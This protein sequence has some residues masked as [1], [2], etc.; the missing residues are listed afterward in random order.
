MKK[1]PD[2]RLTRRGLLRGALGVPFALPLLP[3][4]S[5]AQEASAP[6]KRFIVFFHPNGTMPDEW[7]PTPGVDEESFVLG[8]ILAPLE[9]H[10][11]D[12]IIT[13]G[14]D[15]S[16][17]QQGP[18]EPHQR[19]MGGLLTGRPLLEGEFV[20][21]DGSLAGWGSG[22]SVDQRIA[23]AIGQSTRLRS[24]LLGVRNDHPTGAGEVRNRLSYLGPAQPLP[25]EGDPVAAFN[26]LFSD[27]GTDPGALLELR[28]RRR[29]VLDA[30]LDQFSLVTPKLSADDRARLDSHAALVRDLE[31]RL[32]AEM[33]DCAMPAPPSPL[34][35]NDEN[36]MQ[37][38]ARQH[39]DL[40]VLALS[41][42][43]TRVASL[44][45]SNAQ[46]HIRFPWLESYGDGHSLSHAGPSNSAAKE[47][48]VARDNWYCQQ[49]AYLL[50]KLKEIPEGDG[51]LLDNTCILWVNELSQG[52]THSH[53]NMPFVLAGSAGGYFRTGRYV[54]FESASHNDLLLSLLRAFDIDDE[55]FGDPAFCTGPLAAL[56]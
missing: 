23:E 45:F 52:N 21:G 5:R 1:T 18:G 36:T 51:T 8:R 20:G 14:I 6:P 46:N 33:G 25:P 4:L 53:S 27:M 7:F 2:L 44:Q 43:L 41:C 54:R 9:P 10:R 50:T 29:S 26:L 15:L 32:T 49:L 16:S 17:L 19:G 55:T 22:I 35:V 37:D 3:S 11:G 38:I 42:D 31:Q 24:L 28:A 34:V 48:W 47:E 12:V 39:I 13:S 56:T 40:M 30:V